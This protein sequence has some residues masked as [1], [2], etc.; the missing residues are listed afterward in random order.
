M[1][2]HRFPKRGDARQRWIEACVNSYLLRLEYLQVVER[3]VF[4]WHRQMVFF[5]LIA[6]WFRR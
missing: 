4:V 1:T 5:F 2:I 3:K 6:A